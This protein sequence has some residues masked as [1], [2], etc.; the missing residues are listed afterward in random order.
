MYQHAYFDLLLHTDD[1]LE[2]L[3]QIPIVGRA[4]LLGSK[5]I[6][7][8]GYVDR[9]VVWIMY[10]LRIRWLTECAVRWFPAGTKARCIGRSTRGQDR[11]S[12]D[13]STLKFAQMCY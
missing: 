3:L 12:R 11:I 10:L 7:P 6:E 8:L 1:E 5:V 9:G 2:A 4:T 13:V